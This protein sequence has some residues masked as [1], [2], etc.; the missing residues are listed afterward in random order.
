VKGAS[1]YSIP[2]NKVNITAKINVAI[3]PLIV[4]SRSPAIIEWC[5]QVTVAPEL[6]SKVV[7]NKGTSNALIVWIPIGGQI[8]PMCNSG[9]NE[10][11]KNAQKNEKKNITSDTMNNNIPYLR[12]LCTTKV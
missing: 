6:S 2:C 12:P 4:F 9:P 3:K 1:Q 10:L 11:W 8:P 7:F 5:A